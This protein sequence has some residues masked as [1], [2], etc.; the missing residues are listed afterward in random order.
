MNL[1]IG[2]L[3]LVLVW[4]QDGQAQN[5]AR[6]KPFVPEPIVPGG[7]VL[8]LYPADS[9]RLKRERINEVERYNTTLK[10]KSDR[11]LNVLNIHNPSIEVHLAGDTPPN[12]G[13]AVRCA[14]TRPNGNSIL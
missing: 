13:A 4:C 12:T 6:A 7:L 9:P 3:V 11:T 2:M 8:S 5:D 1:R 14:F 10:N